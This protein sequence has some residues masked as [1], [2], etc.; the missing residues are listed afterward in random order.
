VKMRNQMNEILL[1]EDDV[2][3]ALS[4]AEALV[5]AGYAV[6]CAEDGLHALEL[7]RAIEPAI[8]IVDLGLPDISGEQVARSLREWYP[9]LP[10]VICT[11]FDLE[12][13]ASMI[14]DLRA[15]VL[16]KPLD[17]AQLVEFLRAEVRC[18][19]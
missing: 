4:L 8:A 9:N 18:A 17:D 7:A 19:S 14:E 6:R 13:V 5:E 2:L 16:E 11:G 10:L 3:T 1:V 15:H 12:T